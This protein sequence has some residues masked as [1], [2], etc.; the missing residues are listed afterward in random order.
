MGTQPTTSFRRIRRINLY[1]GPGHG[2]TTVYADLLARLKKQGHPVLGGAEAPQFYVLDLKRK[3]LTAVNSAIQSAIFKEQY[4][5]EWVRLEAERHTILLMESNPFISI[6]HAAFYEQHDILGRMKGTQ[7]K[8]DAL[9]PALHLFLEP[10]FT[11]VYDQNGRYQDESTAREMHTFQRSYLTEH[12]GP[13]NVHTFGT[14]EVG[15]MLRFIKRS[16][17]L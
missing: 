10:A 17:H 9:Y 6:M 12:Y 8:L 14:D 2:K 16:C 3:G 11:K 5:Q 7:Q 15:K 13:E 1:A 4:Q